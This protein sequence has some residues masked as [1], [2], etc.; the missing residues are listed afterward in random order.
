MQDQDVK[1]SKKKRKQEEPLEEAVSKKHGKKNRAADNGVAEA[2]S[3]GAQLVK[4]ENLSSILENRST[5]GLVVDGETDVRFPPTMSFA[6]TGMPAA[7]MSVCETFEKPSPV[8]AQCWPIVLSGRDVV[9][10]AATGSG[11][12]LA[13]ALPGLTRIVKNQKKKQKHASIL[14]LAPTRELAIQIFDVYNQAG[15]KCEVKCVCVYGGVAKEQQRRDLKGAGVVIAT[16]GRLLDLIEEGACNI[17]HVD[18][19]VLDEADRM[20][21]M[22]FEKDVRK[23]FSMIPAVHQTVMFSA[24]W[25]SSIQTLASDLLSNPIKVIVGSSNLSASVTVKQIVEVVEPMEKEARLNELLKQ[26]HKKGNR[27]LVFCLYKKE[28]ARIESVLQRKGWTAIGIHG[29][30]TQPAREQ[31]LQAFKNGS[32][33]ILV[34]TDVAARGLDIKNVEYVINLTF[35]LT[36]EDY[37]HRIGR[38]GRAGKQGISHTLFSVQE[39]ALAGALVNVL[40]ETDQ[41]VPEELL[42]FGS[43]VKRKEHKMYGNHFRSDEGVPAKSSHTTFEDDD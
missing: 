24:T 15:N 4:D 5:L 29:D 43:G 36:I 26:Y 21:D 17:E 12:T 9:G 1:H 14:V 30:M 13:Y 35:P 10:I 25:P 16:P 2:A 27:V 23:I 42:K 11:K 19:M 7:V 20:L 38:T 32:K 33:P 40:R 22:G 31:A 6:E 18:Y 39:K 41:D 3:S 28:A 34:A 8:Q 37:V